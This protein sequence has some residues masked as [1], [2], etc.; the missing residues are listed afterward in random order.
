LSGGRKLDRPG[1]FYEPTVLVN[2]PRQSPAACEEVFGP[3]ALL[4]RAAN[5]DEAI[6]LANSTDLA[7]APRPGP[8]MNRS[9]RN[10]SKS[11]RPAAYSLTDG[12]LGSASPVWWCENS[13]YGRELAEFGIREFVNIKTVWIK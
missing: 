5:I 1:H 10:W 12:R 4:F 7:W 6:R 2:I 8:M 13:G 11:W 3:V 9:K